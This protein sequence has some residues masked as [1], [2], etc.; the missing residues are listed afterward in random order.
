MKRLTRIILVQWYLFEKQE[1]PIVG[2]TAIVGSNGAGK[3]SIIDA[4][5]TVLAGGDK[6][7]IS[8]NKGSNERSSRTIREYCLGIVSDPNSSV[9]VEPRPSANTYLVLCF[10]DDENF[11][12]LSAGV[13]IWSSARDPKENF[14]GYFITRDNVPLTGDFFTENVSGGEVTLPWNDV[15]DR[16]LRRYKLGKDFND[17]AS[18]ILP[19]KGS[20]DFTRNLY[21][22]MSAEP[23]AP[24]NPHTI[25]KSLLSAIA[26]KPIAD[27]TKFIQ[28]N[29][30][31]PSDINIRDLK[32][33]LD[34]W[35][36]LRDKAN[37]T[38][39]CIS[40]LGALE[41][42]CENV[43]TAETEIR[44]HQY[45]FMAARIEQCYEASS[46][47]QVEL[48]DL[49]VELEELN[50]IL[51]QGRAEQDKV[52]RKLVACEEER[53]RQDV[54]QK[55][56][57]HKKEK[58]T[59]EAAA[60][61]IQ[62]QMQSSRMK[63]TGLADISKSKALLPGKL[64][65][66]A[67]NLTRLAK[68]ED[69][70]LSG[71]WPKNPEEVDR[72]VTQVLTIYSG[73]T[74]QTMQSSVSQLWG[75][76]SPIVDENKERARIIARLE[77]KES[78]LAQKTV[79]LIDLLKANRIDPVPLCDLIDVKDESWRNTIEAVLGNIREALIVP[80]NLAQSAVRIYRYEGGKYRGAHIVNTTKT[81]EW[82]DRCQKGSLAELIA[83]DDRHA[84]AFINLRLGN[85]ICVESEADLLK[86]KRAATADLMLASG[87]TTT[88]MTEPS[89]TI[90]GR[91]N[92]EKQLARLK[93]VQETK[94]RE[95]E[96]LLESQKDLS[97]A[98]TLLDAFNERFAA[99][100]SLTSQAGRRNEKLAQVKHLDDEIAIL[101][102]T[103]DQGLKNK[104]DG[105]K[106]SHTSLSE[107]NGK[108]DENIRTKAEK[109]GELRKAVETHLEMAKVFENEQSSWREKYPELDASG[110]VDILDR[111]RSKLENIDTPYQA[112]IDAIDKTI[113][114]KDQYLKKQHDLAVEGLQNFLATNKA[115]VHLTGG[116][117][118]A[119]DSFEDREEFISARKKQLEETT[120]ASYTSQATI[121]LHN[122]EVIF[123]DKFIGRL[124]ERLK[125]VEENIKGLNRILKN[126]PFNGEYYQFRAQPSS[127]LKPV[128]DLAVDFEFDRSTAGAI[129]GL[130]DPANDQSSPHRAAFEYI[131]EAFQDEARGKLVQDYRNYFVFDVEM[132]L[133]TGQKV[134]NMKHRI[135][136]GSGGENMAPFYVAI[137]S[138]LAS[139][140]KLQG[141]AGRTTY[142][143]MNLAPFDE[144]FSKLD[145]GNIFNCLEF[146]KEISL[147]VLLA[148][149][150]DKYTTLASQMNTMVWITKDG[151]NIEIEVE[152]LSDK[153]HKLLRSDNP[154][155]GKDSDATP[156]SEPVS[157]VAAS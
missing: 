45:A 80:P 54:A 92:R 4:V 8:L 127:E 129:G 41:K 117:G 91:G 100:E 12:Y 105:L 34:F 44:L 36:E 88:M 136:K 6:N 87:G 154:F 22:I 78:P 48:D 108:L 153:T 56:E 60:T 46:P 10:R 66:V 138:S 116:E 119:F 146:L 14:C 118:W 94:R 70:L 121:A 98:I 141:R 15:R 68:I 25:V 101:E 99:A 157:V 150:D 74:R 149:P 109:R 35:R 33:S 140:Y 126:R 11:E 32:S 111:F 85:I 125:D 38:S 49:N 90:L 156:E 51:T 131:K 112:V 107:K 24:M 155:K 28:Q 61:L 147:Q 27:P 113:S 58:K 18:L 97:Q 135:A 50:D 9:R 128:Y 81:E 134:A 110:A 84:R 37:Q 86:H 26:F 67:E 55:I 79:D 72:A 114:T 42:F 115:Q 62:D 40:Q 145:A 151:G 103:D 64:V 19:S 20:G 30:L 96:K 120:L 2:H 53:K 3:S 132:F 123:R 63:M 82:I 122:V 52:F 137:G 144:A 83:T 124:G 106:A 95:E 89:Y 59:L 77:N 17:D 148:A 130:F 29:M 71:D 73:Q 7:R 65:P 47:V 13:S 57:G 133:L 23:G 142:G 143:G 16:L 75:R 1:I 69:D 31:D 21:T 43:R 139:A 76:I 93:G 102:A 39:E 152:Y 104:I 5:Q